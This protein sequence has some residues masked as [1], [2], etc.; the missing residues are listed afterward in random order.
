MS[1]NSIFGVIV[2]QKHQG[3]Q[4]VNA[5]ELRGDKRTYR[6]ARD[7]TLPVQRVF[8]IIHIQH[9]LQLHIIFSPTASDILPFTNLPQN[10]NRYKYSLHF[11]RIFSVFST[12]FYGLYP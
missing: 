8:V 11:L 9:P 2:N 7:I 10:R 3:S 6:F 12:D 1:Y 5:G 4:A